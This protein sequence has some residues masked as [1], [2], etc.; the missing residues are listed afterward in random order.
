[1]QLRASIARAW[2]WG[3]AI[4]LV[5]SFGHAEAPTGRYSITAETVVDEK[6]GLMWQRVLDGQ[7]YTFDDAATY[8]IGLS[9]AQ[10]FDWRVPSVKE[11]RTLVD[12]SRVGPAIDE[13][14]FPNTPSTLFW[15]SS[16]YP[17]RANGAWIVD[18]S[19][20]IVNDNIVTNVW[21]VRCVR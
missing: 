1:M 3:V 11:L 17:S 18:F 20:G 6:T 14:A 2:G 13:G 21:A 10:H 9:L 8:C 4:A 5:V 15:T 19:D 16:L 7:A 12:E